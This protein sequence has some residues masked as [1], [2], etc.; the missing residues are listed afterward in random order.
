M[1]GLDPAIHDSAATEA[2]QGLDARDKPRHG[3]NFSSPDPWIAS[4]TLAMTTAPE[5]S[6]RGATRRANARPTTG[7]AKHSIARQKWI[8]SSLSLLAK[9]GQELA[10]R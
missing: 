8:A 5:P 4:L 10:L 2:K 3:D 9:T 7:S 1:A 6:L